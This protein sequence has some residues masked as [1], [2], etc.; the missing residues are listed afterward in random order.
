MA[1]SLPP[2]FH[3]TALVESADIGEATRIWA[4]AHVLQG[5]RIGAH[6]NIGDHCFIE[7]GV[8][9]GDRVT[10][11]NGC[12]LWEGV[13]IDD[14][15][16]VGPGV[17]FT[18]DRYPRSPRLA[19]AAARYAHKENW[20]VSTRVREGASLGAGAV[21]AP[22]VTVGRYAMIAAGAVVTKDV[23]DHTLVRGNPARP[24][25]HVCICGQTL[26]VIEGL[27]FRCPICNAKFIRDPISGSIKSI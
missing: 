8:V 1:E 3:A 27:D 25:G 19:Q 23:A 24:A 22:G 17:V 4:F 10:I 16:F 6:C 20:L 13:S 15:A 9:I 26:T 21:I 12:M 5:A 18:N 2:R 14:G 7:S 11:K